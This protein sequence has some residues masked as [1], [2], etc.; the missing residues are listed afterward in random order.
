MRPGLFMNTVARRLRPKP[1]GGF[2][3]VRTTQAYPLRY[4]EEAEREKPR[5]ARESA[6]AVGVHE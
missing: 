1:A 5:R 6:A 4:F 2:S 3:Q